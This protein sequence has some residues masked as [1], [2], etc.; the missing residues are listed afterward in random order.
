MYGSPSGPFAIITMLRLFL[1]GKKRRHCLRKN[2]ARN[3]STLGTKSY[4]LLGYKKLIIYVNTNMQG[5]G[6]ETL[7]G[8]GV[9]GKPKE[10]W[11]DS[12]IDKTNYKTKRRLGW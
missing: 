3:T 9:R 1:F 12:L 7:Q 5:V 8:W 2:S 4:N 11:F 6:Y 10:C